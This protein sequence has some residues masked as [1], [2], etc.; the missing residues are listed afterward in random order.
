MVV[1]LA[2]ALALR[3]KEIKPAHNKIEWLTI[4]EA[5][6]RNAKTPKKFLVDVYTD[7]CGWCKRMD[8]TT[9]ADAK[10]AEYVNQNFYAVKLNAEGR[11]NI[12]FNNKVYKFM[13]QYKSHELAINLLSGKMSYPSIAYLD[14][15]QNLIT[16]VPGYQNTNEMAVILNYLG[17]NHY[18]K[19]KY[20]DF[21]KSFGAQN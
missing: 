17:G 10:I 6:K 19:S 8:A 3:P 11:D 13:P 1:V 21:K 15:K 9:F 16:V 12:I 2:I 5:A 4:E 14:E 7:W 20:E 18:K